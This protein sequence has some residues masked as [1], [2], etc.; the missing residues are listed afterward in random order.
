MHR[1]P[2]M[3]AGPKRNLVAVS[4]VLRWSGRWGLRIAA[5]LVVVILTALLPIREINRRDPIQQALGYLG[6][7]E[8]YSQATV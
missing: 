5:T 2:P 3:T 4:E 6:P 8:S 7:G 1:C